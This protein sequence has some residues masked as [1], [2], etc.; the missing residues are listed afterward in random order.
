MVGRPRKAQP[1]GMSTVVEGE[2]PLRHIY[3]NTRHIQENDRVGEAIFP[4]VTI[5]DPADIMNGQ[6]D[7]WNV[8]IGDRTRIVY[9]PM[10]NDRGVKVFIET[11][12]RV[13]FD[14]NND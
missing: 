10:G 14:D 7:V 2:S 3:V 6:K 9:L 1:H 11:T 5:D 8:R 4:V 12:E 13:V